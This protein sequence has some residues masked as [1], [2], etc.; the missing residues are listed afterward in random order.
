MSTVTSLRR[1]LQFWKTQDSP[2]PHPR[3]RLRRWRIPLVALGLLVL[4]WLL[5]S[6]V[7]HS[8]LLRWVLGMAAA[9]LKGT[10]RV[11]SASL[12]W[13]SSI[14]LRGIEIRDEQDQPL[15]QAAEFSIDKSLLRLLWNTSALGKL[16]LEQP[17]LS[18]VSRGDGSNV[19]D[20]LANYFAPS[21]KP[22][23]KG[24]LVLE[25]V[26]GSISITDQGSRQTAQLENF[27]LL[28]DMSAGTNGPMHLQASAAIADPQHPGRLAAELHLGQ[29]EVQNQPAAAAAATELS[30]SAAEVPLAALQSLLARCAVSVQL[31]GRLSGQFRTRWEG[32]GD[33]AKT[34]MEVDLTADELTLAAAAL[35]TDRV[36]LAR[37]RA[38][39]QIV[40]QQDRI[41]IEKSAL[42]CD[43]ATASLSGTL[44]LGKDLAESLFDSALHQAYQVEAQLDLARLAAMLPNTLRIR[45]ETQ[46]TAGEVSLSLSGGQE[47]Q[48]M[49]WRARLEAADLKA[50][51]QGRPLAWE[52]PILL[53][54]NAHNG[55]QGPVVE[56]FQCESDF[57]KVQATGTLQD[58]AASA[59]FNLK[60]LADQLGQFIDLGGIELAGSGWARFHWS[61]A[62]QQFQTLTELQ[63]GDFQLAAQ[64][65]KP[66]SEPSLALSVAAQGQ[67]DL[68][69]TPDALFAILMRP[70]AQGKNDRKTTTRLDQAALLVQTETDRLDLQLTAPVADLRRDTWPVSIQAKGQLAPWVTRLGTLVS[71]KDWQLS[72]G[73][74]LDAP[75]ASLSLPGFDVS[76]AKLD[77]RQAKLTAAQLHVA[78]PWVNI[79]E[80]A[81]EL[82]VAGGWDQAR[83]KLQFETA[84]LTNSTIAVRAE[85]AALA[86][87]AGGPLELTGKLAWRG[88]LA[89]LQQCFLTPNTPPNW[90]FAGQLEGNATLEPIAGLIGGQLDAGVTNLAVVNAAGERFQEPQVRLTA[91]GDYDPHTALMRLAQLQLDAG[92]IGGNLSGRI[93]QEPLPSA[94]RQ[95]PGEPQTACNIDISG[96]LT[97]DLEKLLVLLRPYVGTGVRMVGRNSSPA[98]YRGPLDLA[99]ARAN[100]ALKW[101]SANLYGFPLGPAELKAKLANGVL[102]LAEP[103]D[104]EVSRGRISLAPQ[105]RLAPAPM[106][107]TLPAGPLVRQVQITPEMCAYGLKYI[108]PILADVAEAQGAFSIELSGCRI[109]LSNPAQGEMAGRLLIHSVEIGPG[110]M[111]R[112]LAILFGRETPAKLRRESV[113]PFR[114]V[115]GRVYHEG[116]ELIFPE[117]TIRTRGSV[118]LDQTIDLLAEMPVPPQWLANTPAGSAL[119][120]QTIR[121]P[122]RGTLSKPEI[123][124]QVL[125]QLSQ[126][127]LKN[128]AKNVL[129]DEVNRQLDRLFTPQK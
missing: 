105:V 74:Q 56:V 75:Q 22:P 121:L 9:D 48:G 68:P 126:Q 37:A 115:G 112:V 18:V 86:M 109:P 78:S 51:E 114:M 79:D 17:R 116:L 127:F 81:L 69:S 117:L 128:A 40:W 83:R 16:R 15:L 7:A 108:A 36:R 52:R 43:A 113:V 31:T 64:G 58:L 103:L 13:F 111:V 41:R 5:P 8:F 57:L 53:I 24:T 88:D 45:K 2:T 90:R 67:T 21:E 97:Y 32:E 125:D 19:E 14:V 25:A 102:G 123:D 106:E 6:I 34:S 107:L 38:A 72:G 95:Q 49:T 26:D 60:Q 87:P 59:S 54:L 85:D 77:V 99:T 35:G 92:A 12:G 129:E 42:E 47:A 110:P 124:R 39:C 11:E 46:I 23:W 122:M 62:E 1:R 96:Q 89:R 29:P 70:A 3:G 82:D 10:V 119:R 80:P 50:V 65:Q 28:L 73:Y 27:A 66:W 98:A 94:A 4:V 104:L 71:L 76:K 118:G 20:A 91:R 55:P 33:A 61:R 100:A 30:L 44:L 84:T 101:D 120:N 63:V 93:A